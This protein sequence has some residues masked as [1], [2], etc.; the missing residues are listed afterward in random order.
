MTTSSDDRA[1][2]DRELFN[3]V[4][5]DYARKDLDPTSRVARKQRLKSTLAA[6]PSDGENT[7]SKVAEVGCGAG[8][9]A[10]YLEGCYDEFLG[11]D[12]SS[13]LIALARRR[14]ADRPDVRFVVA[15]LLSW[16]PEQHFD[17]IF[18]IGVLHHLADIELA[19]SRVRMAVRPGGW[20]VVNEPQP[21]NLLIRQARKV[22]KRMDPGYSA[23]QVEL[24]GKELEMMFTRAGFT[25]V[26]SAAQGFLATP[27]AEVVLPLGP[28]GPVLSNLACR[29]DWLLERTIGRFAQ[30]LAWN[31]VVVGRRSR[32][33]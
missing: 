13:E 16:E 11:V 28:F 6:V 23:D 17:M 18:A 8:F 26:A 12:Y 25:D 3:A 15:D 30:R 9:A 4:A 31:V 29:V 32:S 7:Y 33:G 5:E 14:Y 1:R 21:G 10:E 20:L 24:D 27:F 19:L 22:R 2:R